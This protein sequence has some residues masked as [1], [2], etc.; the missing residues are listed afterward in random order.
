MSE[1]NVGAD[2]DHGYG[3]LSRYGYDLVGSDQQVRY[4]SLS[5]GKKC[6][7]VGLLA[8]LCVATVSACS[9]VQPGIDEREAATIRGAGLKYRA[10]LIFPFFWPESIKIIVGEDEASL[11][12][13]VRD[14]IKYSATKALVQPGPR[15]VVVQ[16][17]PTFGVIHSC[18]LCFD[19]RASESYRVRVHYEY[20][21]PDLWGIDYVD[22]VEESTGFIMAEQRRFCEGPLCCVDCSG[23]P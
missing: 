19:L 3:R 14:F 12:E 9:Y 10:N 2:Q 15:C 17:T 16:I 23:C 5:A 1:S 6:L 7:T 8:A 18:P 11:R 13:R 22:I 21:L 4:S 20:R